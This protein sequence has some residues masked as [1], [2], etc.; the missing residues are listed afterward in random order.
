MEQEPPKEA[1]KEPRKGKKQQ[2]GPK[3]SKK[4]ESS[5]QNDLMVAR[6]NDESVVSK[7]SAA[8]EHYFEDE[9]LAHFVR[10]P[11]KRAALINRGYYIRRKT[12]QMA[13]EAFAEATEG[14]GQIVSIGA[15]Y[16]STF[17]VLTEKG[18]AYSR[19]FEVDFP[20]VIAKKSLIMKNTPHLL[21]LVQAPVFDEES[22]EIKGDNYSLIGADVTVFAELNKKLKSHG[23]DYSLPTLFLAECV[24]TYMAAPDSDRVIH[25]AAS[26]PFPETW[27]VVY[28]QIR[29]KDAFGRTMLA[30]L[31]ARGSPLL[32]IEAYPS[33]EA[34]VERYRKLG[35]ESVCV[36]TMLDMYTTGLTV[37]EKK[38]IEE[39]EEFDEDEEWR[40][41]CSHY[42]VSIGSTNAERKLPFSEHPPASASVVVAQKAPAALWTEVQESAGG[43]SGEL[44]RWGHS[45]AV[46]QNGTIV[47]FGGYGGMGR[48][49]RMN[50]VVII[51]PKTGTIASPTCSGMAPAPRVLHAC[52]M[53]PNNWMVIY[54]GRA[55]PKSPFGD[56][57][58]LSC[59]ES[60]QWKKL[61]FV[62]TEQPP[63]LYRHTLTAIANSN[64]AVVFG[65][66]T[67]WKEPDN[68]D[69]WI[70]NLAQVSWRRVKVDAGPCARASH[71]AVWHKDAL[72][73]HGGI[74]S[75]G[76]IL[77]DLWRITFSG[78]SCAAEQI[79]DAQLPPR[80]S[81]SVVSV[82][83][84]LYLTGGTNVA[85]ENTV[86]QYNVE[87][88]ET[89]IF[90]VNEVWSR[91]RAVYVGNSLF[92]IGGGQ[93][94]FSFGSAFCDQLTR[95]D[96][97]ESFSDGLPAPSECSKKKELV[98]KAH[99]SGAVNAREIQRI[100]NPTRE[101]FR[102][103]LLHTR[104]PCL[105]SG[106]VL[107][108][109]WSKEDILSSIPDDS[110]ASIHV[111]QDPLLD[112][113]N[114]N[115]EFK[116]VPFAD[117]LEQIED[118][119][120]HLYFRSL[121]E[122]A[123]KDPSS[124]SDS[125]P[126]LAERFLVPDFAQEVVLPEKI[127]SSCLR[128][129]SKDVQMWTHYD[130]NDNLLCGV[131]GQKRLV[132]WHPEEVRHLYAEGTASAVLNVDEPD[133]ERFPLFAK[134]CQWQ[135][136]LK[137]GDVLF[138]PAMWWHNTR[139]LTPCYGLNVFFR[140]MAEE[141][142]QSKDLYGNK[143]PV[144]AQQA[145]KLLKQAEALL[146]ELPED[147]RRFFARKMILDIKKSLL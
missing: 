62:G 46:V 139:T 45:A 147:Y 99:S 75:S 63:A 97:T 20:H 9:Y 61:V 18:V 7:R 72:Y 10:K 70:F 67:G 108:P 27:F 37:E 100:E 84:S 17:F 138:I 133:L 118:D 106:A 71:V 25:W 59:D 103:W 140:H 55:G 34:H 21:D 88:N 4:Q 90:A 129:S 114:K 86:I 22:K 123:R 33:D 73:I 91:A 30:N 13:L 96:F 113:A 85:L 28:E 146:A 127:H 112:F 101:Q 119:S 19:Y 87:Q 145:E 23:L 143:D 11:S 5:L 78:D 126:K 105:F 12:V 83:D 144:S 128:F 24:F 116:V 39:K 94:C 56:T 16:D 124:I 2:K 134:A 48:H 31:Q 60:F 54:G 38:R 95:F 120:R 68:G 110:K 36:R 136:T 142:Y 64:E 53:M 50:D 93:L 115:Y 80:F 58:V 57:F 15:G 121:G 141:C 51:D 131:R 44:R 52:A 104:E 125:F 111:C 130:I 132:L 69:F 77:S 81:H 137:E 3:K 107:I 41:K 29:P 66:R 135:G 43:R 122:N 82:G 109:K 8:R 76:E 32:G 79:C 14:R 92:L 35:F 74:C 47:V 1:S 89:Q 26:A 42:T 102:D 98:A 117:M 49:E 65:G 40:E 6:T